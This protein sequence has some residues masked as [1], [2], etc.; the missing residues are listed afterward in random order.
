MADQ[1]LHAES[2]EVTWKLDSTTVYGTLVRPFGPGPFPAVVMVAGSGPTDRDWNSPL[3]PGSNGSGRLIAEALARAGIASL[4][5]DKRASGPHVRENIQAM[6]G[7]LSMQS[8]VDEL[9]GAVRTLVSQ[10]YVRSDRIF[11]LT[12]SEGAFHALNYQLH[13]PAMPFAGLVLTAPPGRPVGIVAR[14]QL[15]AQ[16][17]GMPNEGVLLALYDAA[18]AR[19]LAGDPIAPDP[20]LPEGVQMLLMSLE[21]PANLPFARELWIADAAP[22]LRQVNIP[23]LVIIGK[24]DIQVDWQADGEPL[25]RAAAGHEEATFLF[26]ENANH[27][28]KQELRPREDVRLAEMAEHYN[29]PDTRL[30]PQA[31]ASILEWLVAHA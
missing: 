28:L 16:A 24:K 26:P 8:H 17:S 20:S 30:D 7:K 2:S 25:Q 9:A 19:F 22:L 31:L 27:V 3:L 6:I 10:G 4:R 13:S 5:Y 23:V 1:D 11:A 12:N 21:T 14:S 15:A 18:I 29:S